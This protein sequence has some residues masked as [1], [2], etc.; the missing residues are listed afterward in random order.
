[1]THSFADSADSRPAAKVASRRR[2]DLAG[3]AAKWL[4][5]LRAGRT[6]L[7]QSASAGTPSARGASPAQRAGW[8]GCA[9]GARACCNQQAPARLP[10][11]APHAGQRTGRPGCAL[12]AR[13]CCNQQALARLPPGAPHAGEAAWLAWLR[14]G[15]LQSASANAREPPKLVSQ[16]SRPRFPGTCA[17][18]GP[19]PASP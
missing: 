9:L 10:P 3:L 13:A 8:P 15:L 18:A 16:R 12:G 6:G 4:A 5:W 14:M 7:P 1:M 19:S 17:W 11:G 2:N